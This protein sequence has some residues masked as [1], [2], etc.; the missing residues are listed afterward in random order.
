[1]LFDFAFCWARIVASALGDK[2]RDVLVDLAGIG[3]ADDEPLEESKQESLFGA[4]GV[5]A[6]PKAPDAT[7][8]AE[9]ITARTADGL[10]PL[11]ARD[12]RLNARVNPK[13]GE[14]TVVQYGGG[15]ISLADASD[16]NG[17]QVVIYAPALKSDGTVDKAHA[18]VFDPEA[19]NQSVSLVHALGMALLMTADKDVIIK[20]AA[21]DAY[22]QVGDDGVT[23]NGNV[24]LNGGV[25]CGD[26]VAA[27]PV[28]L[29]PPIVAW[30]ASVNATLTAIAALLNAPGMVMGAA[31]AVP[32]A[33]PLAPIVVATKA[34][35]A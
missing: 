35:A 11:A 31:G 26:T 13:E 33:A 30:A 18:M 32:P 1:L 15:F 21:G 9:V 25:V 24:T 34:S 4:L 7:G 8:T 20:N 28:A 27:Q 19:S 6:R 12:L 3:D 16:G 29:A 17:T 14:V 22:I 5:V 23:L 10:Q 2:A